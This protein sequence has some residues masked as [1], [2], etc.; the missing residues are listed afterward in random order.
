MTKK[1]IL[2]IS[3]A[4]FE[5]IAAENH[6]EELTDREELIR[7]ADIAR[8]ALNKITTLKTRVRSIMKRRAYME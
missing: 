2:D 8:E 3:I 4:A 5:E 7:C 6:Y 1:Q